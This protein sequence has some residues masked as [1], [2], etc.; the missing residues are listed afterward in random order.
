M[1]LIQIELSPDK[2]QVMLIFN[3][4]RGSREM[5]TLPAKSFYRICQQEIS[6]T[7][8]MRPEIVDRKEE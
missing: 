7:D 8:F 2:E 6:H 5:F 3:I 4:G 1:K